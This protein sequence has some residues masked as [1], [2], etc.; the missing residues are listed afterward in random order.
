MGQRP[1]GS[2]TPYGVVGNID[3]RTARQFGRSSPRRWTQAE[4]TALLGALGADATIESIAVRTGH[5]VKAV[6][7]KIARLAYQTDEIHGFAVFTVDELAEL[8]HVTPRQIRRWKE[9]GWLQTKN[10]KIT[11]DCLERFVREHADLVPFGSLPREDQVY[12]T[13]LGY[14]CP[15]RKRFRQSVREILD[16]IGRQRKPRRAARRN[17]QADLSTC[18]GLDSK[19]DDKPQGADE[20]FA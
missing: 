4:I 18:G 20:Q 10:R 16:G 14:P 13:D 1:Q 12:L 6:R 19:D 9:K 17:E 15:E 2:R 7:A 3:R 5:T 8:I 11:E